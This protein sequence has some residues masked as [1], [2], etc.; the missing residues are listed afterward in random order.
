MLAS[1]E[2]GNLITVALYINVV[3]YADQP[4]AAIGEFEGFPVIPTIPSGLGRL[5][6]Q[7]ASL[8]DKLNALPLEPMLTKATGTMG[9]MD[10]TLASLTATLESLQVILEEDS[11]KALPD[12]FSQILAELRQTLESFSPESA[13]GESLGSSV[14]ELNQALRNLEELTR[15]LSAKPNSL[16]FPTDSPPDPIPEASPQ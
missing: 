3:W 2:T 7:V 12:E 14:F 4:A 1:L 11:T 9:T 13:V 6:Q 15:T 16:L 5:E 8:L 10:G